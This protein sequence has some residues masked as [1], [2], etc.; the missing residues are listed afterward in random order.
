MPAAAALLALL[1]APATAADVELYYT[2]EAES[3]GT[4]LYTFGFQQAVPGS[5]NLGWVVFGDYGSTCGS[6]SATLSGA[7]LVG[8]APGP[9]T[10]LSSS[11]GG[12]AGPT[13]SYV[14]D[15]WTPS[16]E[17]DLL[18]WQIRATNL[19]DPSAGFYWSAIYGSTTFSCVTILP[20]DEDGDGYWEDYCDIADVSDPDGIDADG[21]GVIDNCA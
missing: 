12:H 7:T 9:W 5:Y 16:G 20:A 15:T 2:V 10:S 21:D 4:Y 14:L 8:D 18:E 1:S 6:T 11:S 13:W 19:V 17:G 3:S